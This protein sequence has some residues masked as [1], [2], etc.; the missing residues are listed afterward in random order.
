MIKSISQELYETLVSQWYEVKKITMGCDMDNIRE[1][2]GDR[3]TNDTK[4][5]IDV[6]YKDILVTFSADMCDMQEYGGMARLSDRFE[7]YTKEGVFAGVFD[8]VDNEYQ[9]MTKLVSIYTII[10]RDYEV[11]ADTDEQAVDIA[12]ERINDYDDETMETKVMVD[13]VD[14]DKMKKD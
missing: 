14:I 13:G 4:E 1:V 2:F 8:L 12:N 9:N 7:Y 10:R 3:I 5:C 11:E 6:N